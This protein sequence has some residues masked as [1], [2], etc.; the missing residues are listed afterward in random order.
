MALL[1]SCSCLVVTSTAACDR[2]D[3]TPT[4]TPA[5][6]A[7]GTSLAVIAS[8]PAATDALP[9]G[10]PPTVTPLPNDRL[11]RAQQLYRFGDYAAARS[12]LAPLRR[13]LDR[14][15]PLY[16]DSQLLLAQAYMEEKFYEEAIIILQPLLS[17]VPSPSSSIAGQEATLFAEDPAKVHYLYAEA[18]QGASRHGEALEEFQD[19]AAT[20]TWST[21]VVQTKIGELL[22]TLDRSDEAAAAYLQAADASSEPAAKALLLETVARLELEAGRNANA[23]AA[24]EDILA[25]AQRPAYRTQI[26]YQA[27]LAAAGGG[28]EAQAIEYWLS[29]TQE[30]PESIDAYYSLV[31]LINRGYDYDLYERGYI[32]LKSS[33]WI[34]AINAFQA[35]LDSA[36]PADERAGLAMLGLVQ[37]YTGAGNYTM[38]LSTVETLLSSYPD[39]TCIGRAWL[40]KALAQAWLGRSVESHRTYRT[41]AREH[42]ED[43]LAPEALWQSGLLAFRE[44]SALEASVDMLSLVDSFPQSERA[45][46]ALYLL[47]LGAFREEDWAQAVNFFGRMQQD[48]PENDTAAVAYW[49]GRAHFAQNNDLT[50]EVREQWESAVQAGPGEYYSV[51]AAVALNQNEIRYSNVLPDIALLDRAASTIPGDDGSRAFAERWLQDWVVEPSEDGEEASNAAVADDMGTASKE[52]A[53][54]KRGGEPLG[55]L[56]PEILAHPDYRQGTLLLALNRR[57]VALPLLERFHDANQSNPQILYAL[58]LAYE[59]MGAFRLSLIAANSLLLLSPAGHVENAPSYLQRLV[60]PR[61][62]APLVEKEAA[63][64]DI[65]SLLYYSL[66]RQESLFEEGARSFA[67]AQGLAQIIPDTGAWVAEKVAFPNYENEIIYRPYIN[68]WFGA[69][70]LDWVRDFLD[71]NLISALVG[72]NAGP[73]NSQEWREESGSDDALFVEVLTFSEPRLYVQKIVSNYYHYHRLY[74]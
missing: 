51:L 4:T 58:S 13:T 18:L 39:C 31:E 7:T 52:A 25:V 1:I 64:H 40:E 43:P 3:V 11:L 45:P 41:F 61:R 73:G 19:F 34:P 42:P 30:S 8:T 16:V 55:D 68:I 47:G 17:I 37:A 67:A 53:P 33:A 21:E 36:P 6:P 70:Y 22:L 14:D 32:D 60:F 74:N 35:Y 26:Y 46:L 49:L 44:G 28:D 10:R 9:S 48:Y 59:E 38:A 63:K 66:I 12:E 15:D 50:P 56:P 72:Y 27:G 24:Y 29:A 5:P 65:D 54:R 62:F 71:G 57:S 23:V 20:H 2:A 69:Y